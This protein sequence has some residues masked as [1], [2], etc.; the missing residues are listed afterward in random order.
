[1][2]D[3]T[4]VSDVSVTQDQEVLLTLHAG[5]HMHWYACVSN[6]VIYTRF[7]CTPVTPALVR[8]Y[9]MGCQYTLSLCVC[10]CSWISEII[11]IPVL[12]LQFNAS[13][14]S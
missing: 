4:E 11:S 6:H 8:T 3:K 9:T 2:V 5:M 14:R 10:S 13:V 7:S 12:C 1:M